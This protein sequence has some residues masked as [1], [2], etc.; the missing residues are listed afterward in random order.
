MQEGDNGMASSEAEAL[1]PKRRDPKN[2]VLVFGGTGK[3]GRLLVKKVC[4]VL[5]MC[6]CRCEVKMKQGWLLV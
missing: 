4:V 2:A 3:L 5:I 6:A 1:P